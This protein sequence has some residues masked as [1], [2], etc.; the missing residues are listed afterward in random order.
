M[1]ERNGITGQYKLPLVQAPGSLP[2]R[3]AP[4]KPGGGEKRLQTVSNPKM[5]GFFNKV[6]YKS[7]RHKCIDTD[8]AYFECFWLLNKLWCFVSLKKKRKSVSN[9]SVWQNGFLTPSALNEQHYSLAMKIKLVW[10]NVS[11]KRCVIIGLC[12]R[13]AI[14]TRSSF[15]G[16]PDDYEIIWKRHLLPGSVACLGAHICWV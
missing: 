6:S 12:R 10:S 4:Q 16:S 13:R 3:K 1:D 7:H 14:R 5:P 8:G 11:S 2:A 9:D 15:E